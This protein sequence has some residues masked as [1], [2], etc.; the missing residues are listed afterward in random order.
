V[1]H[2]TKQVET[3]ISILEE[4]DPQLQALGVIK[5]NDTMTYV[6]DGEGGNHA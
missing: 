2:T 5:V 1:N 3:L 4:I 6:A